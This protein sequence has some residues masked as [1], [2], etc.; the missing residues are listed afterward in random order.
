MLF[1][2]GEY[3]VSQV[4]RRVAQEIEKDKTLKKKIAILEKQTNLSRMKT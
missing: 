3:R 1:A 4:C 2:I